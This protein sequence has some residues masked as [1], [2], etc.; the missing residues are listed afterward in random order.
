MLLGQFDGISYHPQKKLQFIHVGKHAYHLVVAGPEQSIGD[1][2]EVRKDDRFRFIQYS[3]TT[4]AIAQSEPEKENWDLLFTQYHTI[5]Y[6]DE[7]QPTPYYVRG[8]LS[9][10]ER[11]EVSLDSVVE[12]G[13]IDLDLARQYSY[14]G[15][16]DAMGYDWKGVTI[17]EGTNSAAYRVHS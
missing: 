9:Q 8:V 5:L 4:G 1:T 10:M 14:S 13:Q 7:G 3:L 2:L 16:A 12:F 17:D 11:V 15:K 6:T